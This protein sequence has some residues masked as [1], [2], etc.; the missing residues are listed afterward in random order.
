VNCGK[1]EMAFTFFDVHPGNGSIPM[2]SEDSRSGFMRIQLILSSARRAGRKSPSWHLDPLVAD[3]KRRTHVEL[4]TIC[5]G[6]LSPRVFAALRPILARR[7]SRQEISLRSLIGLERSTVGKGETGVHAA[8]VMSK[9]PNIP[10]V[11]WQ[12]T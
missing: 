11:A 2:R 12:N 7:I 6:G 5:A 1:V 8:L 3:Q 10:G 9:V 4:L